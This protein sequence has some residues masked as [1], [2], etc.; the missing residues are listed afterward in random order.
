M[1]A[2]AQQTWLASQ[3]R[4]LPADALRFAT[5]A[6][7][8]IALEVAGGP[9][10]AAMLLTLGG[11]M[12]LRFARMPVGTDVLGQAVLL[13]SAWAAATGAFE[14][15]PGLDKAAHL[16][17][18]AV[19]GLLLRRVLLRAG[20]LPVGGGTRAAIARVLHSAAGVLV[21]GLL[22]EL[23]EWAGNAWLTDEIRVGYE[24]T[25]GDLVA[26]LAGALFACALAERA[27]RRT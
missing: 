11:A 2:P 5:A 10:A 4:W 13:G 9:A 27:G 26:D 23:G 18:G 8:P 22:W 17:C 7:V 12:A 16:A 19:L 20:L 1:S 21:L 6:S 3:G 24:D 14:L 15:V 25:L